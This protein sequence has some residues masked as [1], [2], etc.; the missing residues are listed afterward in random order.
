L[1]IYLFQK[2]RL[3]LEPVGA[4][5]QALFGLAGVICCGLWNQAR[6]RFSFH[7]EQLP[8]QNLQRTS[9]RQNQGNGPKKNEA[10]LKKEQ[11]KKL[12][13]RIL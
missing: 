10:E 11:V 13:Y 5:F 12:L 2:R 4:L 3:W 6:E 8:M 9:Q 7:R 1:L